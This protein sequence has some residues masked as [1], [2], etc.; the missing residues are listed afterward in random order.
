MFSDGKAIAEED[1]YY[2]IAV[3]L[4]VLN[5]ILNEQDRSI[6]KETIARDRFRKTTA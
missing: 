6:P 4:E 2:I 3:P 1:G 5:R